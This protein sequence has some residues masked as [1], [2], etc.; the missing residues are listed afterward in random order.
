MRTNTSPILA[1]QSGVI[2]IAVV[3]MLLI[4]TIMAA[5]IYNMLSTTIGISGGFSRKAAT[6]SV[7]A[8]QASLVMEMVAVAVT[9]GTL[10]N[11]S[12]LTVNDPGVMMDLL[13]GAG[14]DIMT[15]TPD[16]NPDFTYVANTANGTIN[17]RA[18]VDFLQTIPIAGGSIEFASAYDGVGNG[19][20]MGSAFLVENYVHIQSTDSFGSR[21]ELRFVIAQ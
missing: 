21:S 9:S 8:T 7:A 12:G 1:R 5:S 2:M 14:N 16:N 18:D 19:Q 13:A 20:T 4:M 17:A 6:R 15:D 11:V 10:P 3:V